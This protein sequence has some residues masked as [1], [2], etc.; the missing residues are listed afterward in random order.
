MAALTRGATILVTGATGTIGGALARVLSTA[1]VTH[2]LGL[3]LALHGRDVSRGR[4][5]E[6]ELNARFIPGDVRGS[7]TGGERAGPS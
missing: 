6:A 2:D 1:N 5:L 3:T 7:S 4:R